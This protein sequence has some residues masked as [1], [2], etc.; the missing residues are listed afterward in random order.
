MTLRIQSLQ[1]CSSGLQL[2]ITRDPLQLHSPVESASFLPAA[3]EMATSTPRYIY[4]PLTP[5]FPTSQSDTD[6]HCSS[7]VQTKGS[8][9]LSL[10]VSFFFVCICVED[11]H[12]SEGYS[13]HKSTMTLFS[14]SLSFYCFTLQLTIN[15][16]KNMKWR[17]NYSNLSTEI[18]GV[19]TCQQWKQFLSKLKYL[20]IFLKFQIM[21]IPFL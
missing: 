13:H 2:G 20:E 14:P 21:Q 19:D 18:I 9:S 10:S 12:S 3:W 15:V 8:L 6:A 4:L 7:L 5:C 11:N 17:R 16:R 1:S